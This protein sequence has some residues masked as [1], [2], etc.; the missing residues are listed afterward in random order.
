MSYNVL[1]LFCALGV[2]LALEETTSNVDPGEDHEKVKTLYDIVHTSGV[3]TQALQ[4]AAAKSDL[5]LSG[6]V[7]CLIFV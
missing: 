7:C 4:S 5:M 2:Q 1:E 6:L 3:F